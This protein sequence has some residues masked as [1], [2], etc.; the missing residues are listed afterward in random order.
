YGAKRAARGRAA[1]WTDTLTTIH[2][3]FGN[4]AW[5]NFNYYGGTIGNSDPASY[6]V[7]GSEMFGV[8]KSSPYYNSSKYDLVLGG[9]ASLPGRNT[10]IHNASSNHDS[11]AVAPYFGGNID[12]FG[13]DED[14]IGALC[15]EPAM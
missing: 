2:L 14:L 3:E 9:Q 11:L 5:N 4:E 6:G 13:T 7:R 8:A 15:Q 12:T 10:A 1:P